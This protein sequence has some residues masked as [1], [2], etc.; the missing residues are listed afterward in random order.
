MRSPSAS[1]I[2]PE[3]GRTAGEATGRHPAQRMTARSR[4]PVR[5]WTKAV[6]PRG[7]SFIGET[8]AHCK[9]FGGEWHTHVCAAGVAGDT[10][11]VRQSGKVELHS[12]AE[13]AVMIQCNPRR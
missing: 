8:W 12:L 1:C 4:V 5:M 2:E 9:R 7:A 6:R 13:E 11:S 3:A 10:G